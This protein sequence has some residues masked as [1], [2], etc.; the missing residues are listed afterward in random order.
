M[1]PFGFEI[2]DWPREVNNLEGP[3]KGTFPC[4][5]QWY[6][7]FCFFEVTNPKTGSFKI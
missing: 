6:F 3:Q 2:I 1:G 5:K 4:I 7:F